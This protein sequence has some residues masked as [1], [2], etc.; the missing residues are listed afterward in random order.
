[1]RRFHGLHEVAAEGEVSNF[2]L[3]DLADRS[4]FRGQDN[5]QG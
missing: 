4:L 5:H 3:S 1:M 2:L